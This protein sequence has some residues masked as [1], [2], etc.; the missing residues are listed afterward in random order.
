MRRTGKPDA[1]SASGLS[2]IHISMCIRDRPRANGVTVSYSTDGSSPGSAGAATYDGP[3]R[4]PGNCRVVCAMAVSGAYDLN[5]ET[6]RINIPQRGAAVRPP[7]DPGLPA[8][9]I[10]QTKLD[11]A[12]AV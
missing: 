3:F 7:I 1:V 5:S 2:L 10:Q 9:W 6:L 4:V 11:D 8:R 12:G